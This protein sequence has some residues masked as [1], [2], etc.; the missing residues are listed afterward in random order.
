MKTR[1]AAKFARRRLFD[2]DGV[3]DSPE[4]QDARCQAEA[5]RLGYEVGNV[6]I[7]RSIS[8]YKDKQRPA[9]SEMLDAVEA[10]KYAAVVVWKLDRLT[11]SY[12]LGGDILRRSSRCGREADQRY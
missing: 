4:D 11:R 8:A 3:S 10:G 6:Y 9:L 12:N 7:D 1:S 5:Q 2:P